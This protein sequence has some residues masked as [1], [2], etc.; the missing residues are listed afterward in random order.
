MCEVDR[1]I[2]GHAKRFVSWAF[3]IPGPRLLM[4][5]RIY[6][7]AAQYSSALLIP[8]LSRDGQVAGLGRRTC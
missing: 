3:L 7:D 5:T 1:N 6:Q 4:T 8:R 2:G